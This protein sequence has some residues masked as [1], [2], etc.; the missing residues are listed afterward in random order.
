MTYKT[1]CIGNVWEA[2]VKDHLNIL[3]IY[4]YI[5]PNDLLARVLQTWEVLKRKHFLVTTTCRYMERVVNINR[6][7]VKRAKA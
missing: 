1:Y 6:W 2:L 7:N 3:H 4:K 5:R